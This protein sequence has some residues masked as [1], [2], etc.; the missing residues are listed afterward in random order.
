M[1][2][3]TGRYFV[4]YDSVKNTSTDLAHMVEFDRSS[5][6]VDDTL[7]EIN[8]VTKASYPNL[9]SISLSFLYYKENSNDSTYK[10]D[11]KV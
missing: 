9:E 4:N 7:A 10:N 2:V 6:F 11:L 1:G 5:S 8:G 3:K